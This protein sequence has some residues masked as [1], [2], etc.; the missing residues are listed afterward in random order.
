MLADSSVSSRRTSCPRDSKSSFDNLCQDVLAVNYKLGDA[1]IWVG[2]YPVRRF[3]LIV[4]TILYVE[5]ETEVMKRDVFIKR[6]QE[7]AQ[8]SSKDEA[9][10]I[11]DTVLKTLSERLTEKEAFD[12]ASQLPHELKGIVGGAK[13]RLVKMDRQEFVNKV[14]DNLNITP[15]E[16]EMYIKA[17]FSVLKSA[18]MPGEIRD[19]LDQL[20][21]DLAAML[22]EA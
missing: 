13:E 17:T 14:A 5:E 20:P 16:S 19:V 12:L 11:T 22:A 3:E 4:H 1:K 7:K 8:V 9:I 21:N 10:W 18:I 15:D 6:V 2:P